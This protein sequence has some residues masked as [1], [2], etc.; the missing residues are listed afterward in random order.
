MACLFT[1]RFILLFHTGDWKRCQISLATY[2][3][4]DRKGPL[5]ALSGSFLIGRSVSHCRPS[6]E[7]LIETE[8][9]F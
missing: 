9:H 5:T 2:G 8:E 1:C 7:K 4:N 6:Q 3:P